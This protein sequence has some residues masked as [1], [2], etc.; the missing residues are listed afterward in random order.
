MTRHWTRHIAGCLLLSLSGMAAAAT[1]QSPFDPWPQLGTAPVSRATLATLRGGY[2]IGSAAYGIELSFAITRVSYING[3]LVAQNA[4]TSPSMEGIGTE[5]AVQLIQ[6]GSN[7]AFSIAGAKLPS[8]VL[9]VIQNTIDS[10]VIKNTTVINATVTNQHF[11]RSM[12][13]SRSIDQAVARSLR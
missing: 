3:Q 2:S 12:A 9:T 5:P 1:A 13:V 11:V 10:Q 8:N 4:L 6:N 7:N